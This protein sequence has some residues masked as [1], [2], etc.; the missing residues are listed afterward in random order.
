MLRTFKILFLLL[1]PLTLM[2]MKP[3]EV[4]NVQV[5]DARCYVSDMC[6]VLSA[7][8]RAELDARCAKLRET[9]GA[10]VAI[11]IVP[12]VEDDDEHEFTYEL[13]R[14]W[15][16]G[17][18]ENN[19]G[20]LWVYVV[21]IRA[22]FIMPGLGLEGLLPDIFLNRVLD[23]TVFP[24]MREG[25]VDSA[26]LNGFAKIEERLNSDEA[27]EELAVKAVSEKTFW[28]NLLLGYF[29]LAFLVLMALAIYFYNVS[30]KLHGN[31]ADRFNQLEKVEKW[32][33]ALGI[34]FVLPVYFLTR[35]IKKFRKEQRYMPVS[36][37]CG[38][39]MRVLSEA[40]EDAYLN[41]RQQT[42][43]TLESLD[44]DVWVCPECG[45]KR[46]FKYLGRKAMLYKRC[47]NCKAKAYR[48]VRERIALPPTALTPG[49]GERI[50]ICAVCGY[51]HRESYVI[52]ALGVVAAGGASGVKGGGFHGGGFGGGFTGG[53]GAGGRF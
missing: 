44:Y 46:I 20:L 27:Y 29:G 16:I 4:R 18:K 5:E 30:S 9:R 52:P 50:Y 33:V 53:G 6:G 26:Y 49:K 23:E 47:P 8:T 51:E 28:V 7:E 1:M 43:E 22:M 35:Y 17:G 42:E 36:C 15:G 12:S 25:E 37:S 14:L 40:E 38:A 34:M 19:G 10:E 45:E 21:D 41:S 32:A 2:A 13:F 31:N 11:V 3:E 39:K 48:Q 24:L